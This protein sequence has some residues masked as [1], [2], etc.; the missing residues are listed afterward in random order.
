MA[1][2][3]KSITDPIKPHRKHRVPVARGADLA[4]TP[5][6]KIEPLKVVARDVVARKRFTKEMIARAHEDGLGP[7]EVLYTIAMDP[8]IKFDDYTYQ[9]GEFIPIQRHATLKERLECMNAVLPYY[10]QKKAQVVEQGGEIKIVH[11]LERSP[12]S[13]VELDSQGRVI[14]HAAENIDFDDIE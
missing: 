10:V 14:K 5:T 2:P 12:L 8:S 13:T 9:A 4:V 6:Q 7:H 1:R 3:I 11:S